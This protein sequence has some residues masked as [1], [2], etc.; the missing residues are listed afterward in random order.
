MKWIYWFLPQRAEVIAAKQV[1]K[2]NG[3]VIAVPAVETVGD[4]HDVLTK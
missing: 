2:E 3:F 4:E 1:F